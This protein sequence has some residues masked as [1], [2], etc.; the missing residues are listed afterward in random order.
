MPHKFRIVAL[1]ATCICLSACGLNPQARQ[2]QQY[3]RSVANDVVTKF[4][5]RDPNDVRRIVGAYAVVK[6]QQG[7]SGAIWCTYQPPTATAGSATA[8][9]PPAISSYVRIFKVQSN[10]ENNTIS[11]DLLESSDALNVMQQAPTFGDGLNKIAEILG[12][13]K[14]G[15]D[16]FPS[17]AQGNRYFLFTSCRTTS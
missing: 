1:A 11:Y 13:R 9:S 7:D 4:L 17:D 3:A 10:M 2:Q 8:T 15:Y 16:P 5:V 12:T 14:Q 6:A